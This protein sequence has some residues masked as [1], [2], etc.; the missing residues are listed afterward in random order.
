[1]KKREFSK[2]NLAFSIISAALILIL[3]FSIIV[4]FIGFNT[5]TD[6]MRHEYGDKSWEIGTMA[7]SLINAN[8]VEGYLKNGYEGEQWQKIR[9]SLQNLCDNM[10]ADMISVISV[11]T[12][13]YDSCETVFSVVNSEN[14]DLKAKQPGE[15]VSINKK[16]Y[17]ED[18]KLLYTDDNYASTTMYRT[19]DLGGEKPFIITFIPLKDDSG[20]VVSLVLSRVQM[21][22]IDYRDSYILKVAISTLLL[23][24][25]F[26]VIYARY[27]RKKFVNPI[28]KVSEETD[29]FAKENSLGEKLG[30]LSNIKE[31]SILSSSIDKME[32]E[33]LEYIDNLTAVNAEKERIGTELSIA[34]SIQK[35][36]VPNVFQDREE[37]R[38]FASMTP[39]KEVG[40]DFYN[41]FRVD[42]DHLAIVM[43]DVSG[44]GVPAA[45]FMML[46]NT[47][48]IDRTKMGGTPAEILSFVNDSLCEGNEASMFV[49]VWLGIL[50]ISTGRLKAAN[51]GHEYPAI[52]REGGSFELYR[53]CHGMALG[54]Y[55]GMSYNDYEIELKQG[56][57]LFLYT[58]GVPEATD[59][60][61]EMFTLEGMLRALENYKHEK[62]EAIL[63][64]VE[65]SVNAFVGDAPQFDDLT[66][67]CLEFGKEDS[68]EEN[69]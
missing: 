23:A 3:V 41:F 10:N 38:I 30:Q 66:M 14:E 45:L 25:L 52:F 57:K 53:D 59:K 6:A 60:N 48:I 64:G 21:S 42:E 46:A 54:V 13:D 24:V 40:G 26:V 12:S 17:R 37:F 63:K 51:A 62:P 8:E 34:K 22:E 67:L 5:F 18:I 43:A 56:D 7:S 29:R 69:Q 55:G 68:D 31:I 11:D 19:A 35:N 36:A 39:A 16:E 33:M 2:K 28:K 4:S 61:D 50:E 27:I 49:S 20:K 58:D 1:M 47:S 9:S 44:K 15:I 65:K 32:E